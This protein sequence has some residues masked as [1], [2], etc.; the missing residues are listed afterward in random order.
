MRPGSVIKFGLALRTS[1]FGSLS[2][3]KNDFK[4]DSKLTLNYAVLTL[5]DNMLLITCPLDP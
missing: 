1:C 3:D 4:S 2:E 5:L